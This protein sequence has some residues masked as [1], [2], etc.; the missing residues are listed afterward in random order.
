MAEAKINT[1]G[2]VTSKK[3]TLKGRLTKNIMALIASI[4]IIIA[5]G[6]Y[7]LMDVAVKGV[8]LNSG[9]A[10]TSVLNYSLDG[11]DVNTLNT[12]KENSEVY[13]KLD[14]ALN[15]LTSKSGDLVDNVYILNK[16]SSGKWIYIIDKS[17]DHSGKF[18]DTYSDGIDE[19]KMQQA[20]D[21]G[22]TVEVESYDVKHIS[23]LT[24]IIPLKTSQG[25]IGIVCAEFKVN[26]LSLAKYILIGV[27]LV[28]F[29]I[30]LFIMRIIVG[31]MT[32]NQTHSIDILV[33]K[34]KDMS[35]LEGDLTQR[36]DINSN[37]EIGDLAFYTN[38]MLDTLQ[39]TLIQ[40]SKASKQLINT[41]EGFSRNFENAAQNFEG[42][43]VLT[44]DITSRINDQTEKL[45]V[46][47][48]GI[49]HIN[50]TVLQV[51]QNSQ[52]VTEQ[53]MNTSENA[54]KGNKVMQ[55]LESHTREISNVVDS[56]SELVRR[57]AEKSEQINGIADTIGAIASQTNLLALN[58]SIE[59]ARA[60]EHGK[61]FAVV[62][63]EV[64]KLAEESSK[65]AEEIFS[66]IGEVQKGIQDA[67]KS[68]DS[69]AVKTNEENKFVE[70]ATAKFNEIVKSISDVSN[71]VEEVSAATEEMSANNST[72]TEQIENLAAISQEN[73]ASTE[74]ISSRI[75]KQAGNINMLVSMTKE[76]NS[77]S[78]ELEDKLSKL[79]LE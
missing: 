9:S 71:K 13:K 30:A 38:K 53:A 28:F 22:K 27:L 76:L 36:I 72:V 18:G 7:A 41:C 64:R 19:T 69:V 1:T 48:D 2:K 11:I 49:E 57:L 45:S 42:M 32:K 12:Q 56:T 60:G 77:I 23:R 51:A 63:E 3:R 4:F 52:L 66:L 5:I 25:T 39:S 35:N 8:M 78:L 40:V 24:A 46:S 47:A 61:G 6:L 62:A 29:I 68:M 44:K 74:E 59:A 50:E 34:M 10:I 16:D 79:K 58:A 43:N 15:F 21:T 14:T 67:G 26:I 31:R 20:L 65:S 54:E 37:D 70:D 17:R 73:N 55:Q 75:G 33:E